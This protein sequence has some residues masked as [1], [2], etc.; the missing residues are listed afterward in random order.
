MQSLHSEAPPVSVGKKDQNVFII[1]CM[2][3]LTIVALWIPYR[4]ELHMHISVFFCYWHFVALKISW[5]TIN[6]KVYPSMFL[7]TQS[8]FPPY[9]KKLGRYWRYLWHYVLLPYHSDQT[10]INY[11]QWSIIYQNK[12]WQQETV[13][14]RTVETTKIKKEKKTIP[15]QSWQKELH[16]YRVSIGKIINLEFKMM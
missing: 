2:K 10:P 3:P 5:A 14:L 12:E 11:S 9:Q 16:G 15:H 8:F 1:M 6:Y 13:T 4:R 7:Q